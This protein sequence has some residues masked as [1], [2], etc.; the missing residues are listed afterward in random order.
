MT[1]A[2]PTII[3]VVSSR[4]AGDADDRG[5]G[6]IHVGDDGRAHRPE[7]SDQ[8]EEE[9]EAEGRAHD[10]KPDDGLDHV[11]RG[12]RARPAERGERRVHDGGE[13]ERRDDDA[14]RRR[15]P[16][17]ARED[18]AGRSRNRRRRTRSRSR[19]T[20]CTWPTSS[21]TIATTPAMPTRRPSQRRVPCRSRSPVS[22]A[23]DRTDERNRGDQKPGQ[24]ARQLRLR[25]R[26]QEPG[27]RDLDRRCRARARASA[28]AGREAP[29][30]TARTAEAARRRSRSAGRRASPARAPAPRRGSSGTGF[31]RSRTSR[32]TGGL[33]CGV[34]PLSSTCG[35]HPRLRRRHHRLDRQRR[36]RGG[37]GGAT[38][39]SSSRGVAR[40]DPA[41]FS[42]VAEALDA[43]EADVLVD[44]THAA[45]VK[46]NVA[47]GARA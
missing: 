17:A 39:S 19:G 4:P 42:S 26:E 8:G 46:E 9:D 10:R 1:S 34:I 24:R 27:Q 31:P 44:Y 23:I 6:W 21:P 41:H 14:E 47:R 22:A 36:R 12:H 3:P 18:D 25:L 28:G 45:V 16:R 13:D 30:A 37:R 11:R 33:P 35:C 5:D 29:S 43:V 40:S 7:L 2:K 15:T 32:R 38:I 20:T